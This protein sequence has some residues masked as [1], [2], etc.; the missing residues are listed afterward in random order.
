MINNTYFAEEQDGFDVECDGA[1]CNE[2]E[3]FDTCHF[4]SLLSEMRTSGWTSLKTDGEWQHFCMTCSDR[5]K[6]LKDDL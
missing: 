6:G 3:H 4:D 1:G 2:T 5:R